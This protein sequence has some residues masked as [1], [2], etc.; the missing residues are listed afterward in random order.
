MRHV[1]V[2]SNEKGEQLAT[3]VMNDMAGKGWRVCSTAFDHS[4]FYITFVRD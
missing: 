1:F 3:A 2:T 4:A